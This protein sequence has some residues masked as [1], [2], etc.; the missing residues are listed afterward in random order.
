MKINILSLPRSG[1]TYLYDI[2]RKAYP[3][4]THYFEP[5]RK[6]HLGSSKEET[7]RKSL[8]DIGVSISKSVDFNQDNI[9]TKNMITHENNG[10]P[11]GDDWYTIKLIRNNSFDQTLSLIIALR[12]GNFFI[13]EKETFEIDE[14]Y[15]VDVF[16]NYIKPY[17]EDLKEASA[18]LTVYYEDL[19]YLPNKDL[20]K[21]GFP[22][23][24]KIE[25]IKRQKKK[26]LVVLNYDY[27]KEKY[28][29]I[30]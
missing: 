12:N 25:P 28:G 21:L 18:D 11:Y 17:K 29:E 14:K 8:D 26:N 4:Y 2:F 22:C 24:H 30:S 27:L 1:S 16:N 20:C 5:L 7:I 9:I 23:K 19:S 15:F 10:I 3:D 6:N 13:D